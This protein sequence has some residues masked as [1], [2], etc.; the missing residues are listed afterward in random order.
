MIPEK[1]QINSRFILCGNFHQCRKCKICL[2][3][4]KRDIS[5]HYLSEVH[6]LHGRKKKFGMEAPEKGRKK[7]IHPLRASDR[8][9]KKPENYQIAG[10]VYCHQTL[11]SC[12]KVHHQLQPEQ[13][14]MGN[15]YK[16]KIRK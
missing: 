9:R 1:L 10:M 4:C 13:L 15:Y 6:K 11:S 3:L 12:P 2:F 14:T 16:K 5:R 7:N 8:L